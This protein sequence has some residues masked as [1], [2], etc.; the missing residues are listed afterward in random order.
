M[1]KDPKTQ[2]EYQRAWR[3]KNRLTWFANKTCACCGGTDRL[4]LDH[5]DPNQKVHHVIWSWAVDRREVELAKCQVLCYACHKEKTGQQ[6]RTSWQGNKKRCSYCKE[7]KDPTQFIKC[8]TL[9]DGLD[10]SC[11]ECKSQRNKRRNRIVA[12]PRPCNPVT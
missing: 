4:E 8:A 6:L 1:Y 10:K 9:W 7:F 12:L 3:A 11:K 5:I 2:R